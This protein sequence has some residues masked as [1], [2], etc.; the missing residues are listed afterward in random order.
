[1]RGVDA[2]FLNVLPSTHPAHAPGFEL[3]RELDHSILTPSN[4]G[5]VHASGRSERHLGCCIARVARL[6][7]R[8]QCGGLASCASV[9]RRFHRYRVD[10]GL[11]TP[12][13]LECRLYR[14]GINDRAR[15]NRDFSAASN[16]CARDAVQCAVGSILDALNRLLAKRVCARDAMKCA[17]RRVL[18]TR[19]RLSTKRVHFDLRVLD[20]STPESVQGVVY[21]AL[22]S[23]SR[24][25]PL[26]LHN[27]DEHR[28]NRNDSNA[29]YNCNHVPLR[30]AAF[31]IS[32]QRSVLGNGGGR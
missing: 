32:L 30:V 20:T 29:R 12:R 8:C 17:V 9:K 10:G 3:F 14:Y 18:D 1:M 25:R 28:K 13:H 23:G 11:R 26:H 27:D 6:R 7:R 15:S 21:A 22:I 16:S 19:N 2:R 31:C 24:L 4:G 5:C